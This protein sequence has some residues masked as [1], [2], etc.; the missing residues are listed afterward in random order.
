M[1]ELQGLITF[2][3][4]QQ[5]L[6]GSFTLSHGT[7]PSVCHLEFAPQ[8]SLTTID[9]TLQ[10]RFGPVVLLFPGSRIDQASVRYTSEGFVCSASIFDRRWRWR[11]GEISGHY[12]LR[13]ADGQ[14]QGGTLR[15]PRQL[16]ALCLTAMGETGFDVGQVPDT[17]F[18]EIHWERETPARALDTLCNLVGCRPVLTTTNVIRICRLGFG[19]PLPIGGVMEDALTHDPPERPDSLK[20]VAGPSLF[21][22]VFTLEAVGQEP[23]TP[24]SGPGDIRRIDNLTYRPAGGWNTQS[25]L[26]FGGVVPS[27]RKAAFETVFRWYRIKHPCNPSD[28]SAV[29]MKVPGYGPIQKL[30]QVLPLPGPYLARATDVFA[31]TEND[32]A[33]VEIGAV[34]ASGQPRPAEVHGV[35]QNGRAGYAN[36]D[37]GT[38]Y[39]KPFTID[40]E[41][42]IVKF[43]EPVVKFGSDRRPEPADLTLT[44]A[45]H[46]RH[47][48]TRALHRVEKVYKFPGAA[49]G[50]GPR[51]LLHEEV[52]LA[53]APNY[54]DQGNIVNADTNLVQVLQQANYYLAAAALE[55][56]LGEAK[57]TTYRGFAAIS[58]DGAIQ[59]VT[60]SFGDE[61]ATTRAS[62]NLEWN[63]AV[64]SYAERRQ[65]LQVRAELVEQM[66]KKI[67]AANNRPRIVFL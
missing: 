1:P 20:F 36:T 64:P 6:R 10:L 5:P 48:A 34:T 8:P 7:S 18:P 21:E 65:A 28:P 57:D 31:N 44:I 52:A 11:F 15:T 27:A 38:E 47:A 14:M 45:V 25:P 67:A 56:Q 41:N 35:F 42:A 61:G 51:V 55:Y 24:F 29:Q 37:P 16:V 49:A 22:T 50:T 26:T 40:L 30:R 39:V 9:G 33:D 43:S 62:R 46:V 19:S 13:F 53:H 4:I 66:R 12:N 32:Q 54:N 23:S 63:P 60:W 17:S 2:P 59:Q 58:P 3:G